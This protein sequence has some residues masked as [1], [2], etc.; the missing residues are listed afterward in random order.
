MVWMLNCI[1]LLHFQVET[2]TNESGDAIGF[3]DRGAGPLNIP[4]SQ[5][6]SP[7]KSPKKSPEKSLK[8]SKKSKRKSEGV[9]SSTDSE[10]G[11]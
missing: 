11:K 8:K 3:I 1:L 4:S 2:L 5:G 9:V 6:F 7:M 10:V